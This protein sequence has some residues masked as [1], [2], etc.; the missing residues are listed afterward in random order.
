MA[1]KIKSIA[2]MSILTATTIASRIVLAP[3]PNIKPVGFMCLLAGIV[4]G[5]SVGFMV[6]FLTMAITD[7]SY[8]GAGV[9]TL[10]TATSMGLVGLLG[11]VFVKL[12]GNRSRL[13][14]FI[15]GFFSMLFYDLFTSVALAY[16]FGYSA[17]VSIIMLFLPAPYPLGPAHEI[18]NALLAAFV[19]PEVSSRMKRCPI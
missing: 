2:L 9:W 17:L 16:V 12:V 1:D 18:V 10:V 3:L 5:P 11:S 15:A 7:I 19:I 14:L 13:N 8:F 4:G 6:G